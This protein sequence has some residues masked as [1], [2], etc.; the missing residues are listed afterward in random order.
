MQQNEVHFA[1]SP[2]TVE[3]VGQPQAENKN[4]AFPFEGK[5][6]CVATRMRCYTKNFL[7]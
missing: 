6:G 1:A 5:V 4:K 7:L 2:Q 3:K